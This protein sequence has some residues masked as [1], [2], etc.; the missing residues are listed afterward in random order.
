MESEPQKADLPKRKRRWYQFSLRTLLIGVTLL[1]VACAY[2]GW[3]SKIVNERQSWL[4]EH[5]GL[6]LFQG[7]HVHI[8]L[9]N[10]D[11]SKSPSFVRRW[12]GDKELAEREVA[13]NGP[14]DELKELIS[15]FPEATIFWERYR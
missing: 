11:K 3:Q 9:V 13:W 15:L 6:Q 1:A 10:G 14:P 5:S 8:V 12:L 7:E 4:K 2:V